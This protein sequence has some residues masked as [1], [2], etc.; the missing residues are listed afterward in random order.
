MEISII[1]CGYVGL[2]LGLAL[3]NKFKVHFYDIDKKKINNIKK[4][5]S[6]IEEDQISE[7][8][9][10]NKN[11][12]ASTNFDKSVNKSQYI[13][14][15]TPTDYD[16][17]SNVFNTTSIE[18]TIKKL[19]KLKKK[20]SIIIKSTIPIGYTE[21]LC[22]KY[23]DMDIIFSPEFLREG[24]ALYDNLN[25][26]RIIIGNKSPK[27]RKFGSMLL[28]CINDKNTPM[29]FT[30]SHEAEAIK[31]FS[32]S[33]L[34]MRIAYFNELDSFC[35][36]KKINSKNVIKGISYDPRIGNYYNN[37]SFGYGGYCLPKDTKQLLKNYENIPNNLIT[38]IV[39]SN[40]TRK[41][42]IASNIIQK[43]PKTVGI[44]RINMKNGSDNFR[45]SAIQGIIKR[46]QKKGIR[47]IIY[48]PLIKE[49]Y[50]NKS[51]IFK[52]LKEFKKNSNIIIANRYDKQLHDV[53]DKVYT[54]DIFLRD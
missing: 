31:L 28:D 5:V 32:N 24:K 14:I 9:L 37:P 11:I 50:F 12:K 52:S 27:A 53:K 46:I 51:K 29:Q 22:K 17:I 35:E 54:R 7:Y 8:L 33:Y 15:A 36:M 38:A 6:P 30:S 21:Y 13:V 18:N 40:S 23:K 2:S 48:E 4:K 3:S 44:F 16:P 20:A 42:F 19:L 34:A 49:K 45:T 39:S 10:D 26:S 1:G 47:I 43:N 41:D 25:P